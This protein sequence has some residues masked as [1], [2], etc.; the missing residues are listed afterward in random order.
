[1]RIPRRFVLVAAMAVLFSLA[2]PAQYARADYCGSR[3]WAY[4][5]TWFY[6]WWVGWDYYDGSPSCDLNG[7]FTLG[8]QRIDWGL[9]YRWSGIDGLYGS[10]TQHD[11]RNFQQAQGLTT[12]GL[13]GWSTWTSYFEE[14]DPLWYNGALL[15]HG[16]PGYSSG[17]RNQYFAYDTGG[18]PYYWYTYN[19]SL[20]T[21][22]PFAIGGPTP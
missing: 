9:G 14:I 17:D 5:Y 8:V 16:A 6:N 19:K 12:D 13:V 20:T 18:S 21:W 3:A 2:V 1:M 11:V 15:I 10:N 7:N 22:V 4:G